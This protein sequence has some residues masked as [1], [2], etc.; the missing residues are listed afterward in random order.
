MPDANA[1]APAENPNALTHIAIP[2]VVDLA[3]IETTIGPAIDVALGKAAKLAANIIDVPS[4]ELALDAVEKIKADAIGP[5]EKW[6]E[7][8]YMETHYRPGEIRR[9]IFDSRLKPAKVLVK[10]ILGHV[11]DFNMKLERIEKLAREKAEAD[12]RRAREELERKQRELAE[13]EE[14][15]VQAEAAEK[16]RIK[17]AAEAE[18]RRI[19]AEKELKERREREAREAAAAETQR[20]L[21]E[22]ED[23]RI[24]HA[25]TAE[26]VGN[27]AGKVNMIL[28]SATGI[29]PVLAKPEQAKDLET[30]RLEQEQA[31]RVAEEK[32]LRERAEAEASEKRRVEAETNAQKA[33]DEVA[34]AAADLTAK[35]AAAATTAM[36]TEESSRT[37]AVERWVWDLESDGTEKG[38]KDA[39]YALLEAILKTRGTP[40]EV[41]LEFIGYDPKHP[42][43]F[44]PPK[45][46]ESVSDLKDRF[47]CP[48][49]RAYPQRDERM[50]RPARARAVGG[51][52]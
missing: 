10:T 50:K 21:K 11:S 46:G 15:R 17:E 35:T 40:Q 37:Y 2:E 12:A 36:V 28:D 18:E 31:T 6:R 24:I 7:E 38:D 32:L 43:D 42:E 19:Q 47:S 3:I 29:S 4:R 41:P 49:I 34:K 30:L 25:Q 51:R 27:D 45:V 1:D 33:R 22:E 26:S 9:E 52:K 23:A 14:R 8:Y 16:R 5:L 39:V 44:R 48:G 20:K 13:A